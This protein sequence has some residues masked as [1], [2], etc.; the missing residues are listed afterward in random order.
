MDQLSLLRRCR[1]GDSDRN[2]LLCY[3]GGGMLPP[4]KRC[5][6]AA[7]IMWAGSEVFAAVNLQEVKSKMKC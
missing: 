1:E 5:T 7:E 4:E 6:R 3:H 2:H